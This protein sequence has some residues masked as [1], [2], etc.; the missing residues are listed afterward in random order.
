MTIQIAAILFALS[1]AAIS[2]FYGCSNTWFGEDTIILR[3]VSSI[4]WGFGSLLGVIFFGGIILF[5]IARCL[6]V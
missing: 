3:I 6:G 2:I 5:L 1:W 4:V